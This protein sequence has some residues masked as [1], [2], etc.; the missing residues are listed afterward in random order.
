MPLERNLVNFYFI[1]RIISKEEEANGEDSG[2]LIIRNFKKSNTKFRGSLQ[3]E[4]QSHCT[5]NEIRN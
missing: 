2:E 1:I 3:R 5:E 4:C